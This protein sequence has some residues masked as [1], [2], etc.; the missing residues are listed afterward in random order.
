MTQFSPSISQ[1][2]NLRTITAFFLDVP[3]LEFNSIFR[4]SWDKS[5]LLT[6]RKR[7]QHE[8]GCAVHQC[9]LKGLPGTPT[10]RKLSAQ[11]GIHKQT[12]MST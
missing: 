7:L 12:N 1:L 5:C 10:M 9:G 4:P 2:L 11:K 3:F 8:Q 6:Y